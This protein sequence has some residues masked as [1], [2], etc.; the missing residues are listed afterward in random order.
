MN[1]INDDDIITVPGAQ[2]SDEDM[3]EIAV[4]TDMLNRGIS[5]KEIKAKLRTMKRERAKS[6]E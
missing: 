3:H 6:L 5:T 1:R 4:I 2:L